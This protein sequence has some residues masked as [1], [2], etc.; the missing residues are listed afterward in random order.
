LA[1]FAFVAP[2]AT[3]RDVE[4]RLVDSG[5]VKAAKVTAN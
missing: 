4:K 3:P 5:S 2:A 1:W